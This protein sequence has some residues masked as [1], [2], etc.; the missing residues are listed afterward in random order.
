MTVALDASRGG[1]LLVVSKAA[2]AIDLRL[3][4][5]D[6]LGEPGGFRRGGIGLFQER[7]QPRLL[8]R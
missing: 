6:N 8:R 4:A 5:C 3:E 2:L 1:A 7:L